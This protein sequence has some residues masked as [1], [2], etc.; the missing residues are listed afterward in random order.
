MTCAKNGGKKPRTYKRVATA[1]LALLGLTLLPLTLQAQGGIE[2]YTRQFTLGGRL[3]G[4]ILLVGWSKDAGD[5]QKLMDLVV[6][7]A[8][9]S[10]AR[11]DWRNRSSEV[12]RLNYY[13]GKGPLKVSGDVLAAFQAAHKASRLTNGGFDIA[14][15]GSGNWRDIKI[16]DKASTVELKK[17]GMKVG[18][19][20]ILE[21]FLADLMLSY[22][23][24][25]NMRNAI[26]KVGSVFR[27]MGKDL[28]GPWKIQ[29]RDNEG[30]Y[31][32]HALNLTIGNSGVATI[33]ASQFRAQPLIDL[34][35]GKAIPPPCRGV[36]VVMKEA[37]MAQGVAYAVFILGPNKGLELLKKTK[38]AKGLVVDNSGKFL[39]S[40]G[41]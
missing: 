13:A 26:I 40:P 25:A 10:Y 39:R 24:A 16:K 29:V 38:G 5:I 33:S 37:A 8:N 6:A 23:Y 34:R 22:I 21:G 3:P 2:R 15:P 28:R 32:H 35:S 12:Y 4:A 30:T 19:D 9:E 31:A 7:R 1:G 17:T 14:Y 27:G 20:P 36:T 11:L 41:F 18:F